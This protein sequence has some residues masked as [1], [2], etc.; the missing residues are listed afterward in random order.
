MKIA[1]IISQAVDGV[2]AFPDQDS[3]FDLAYRLHS[4]IW[5]FDI[6]NSRILMA[7]DAAC[8]VWQAPDEAT[9]AQRDLARDMSPTVAKRL[10]QYQTDFTES[11]ARFTELWTIYPSGE[12]KN[13]M[14]VY[15]GFRLKDGRMAMLC[16]AVGEALEQPEN[17]RSAEALLHTDVMITLF[18]RKGPALY[19]NPAARTLMPGSDARFEDLFVSRGDHQHL[20]QKVD[21]L[22]E[23]RMVSRL[24]T[25]A[26]QRWFD[27][28]VKRCSDAVTSDPAILVTAIDVSDLK[29]ARDTAK[30]LADRDQLTNLYNRAYLQSHLSWLEESGL[31]EGH[32]L[33]FFDVD[34]FK[35]VNDRFGHEAGDTVL[36]EI[37]QR[38]RATCRTEDLIVRFGGDEF[39]ILVADN[40]TR[41]GLEAQI[42]RLRTA[43]AQPIQHER[44]K[45]DL[46]VSVGVATYRADSKSFASVL[47]EADI[48]LYRA[49]AA[50]RN[51]VTFFNKTMGDA[52][53]ARETLEEELKEALTQGEFELH[54]QP[55]VDMASGR[56]VAVE[57]L[58]RWNHPHRGIVMPGEFIPVCEETGMIDELG[59]F[60]L[61]EGC[62]QAQMWQQ[63]GLDLVVSLNVS[64]RQ[65]DD[66]D[67]LSTLKRLAAAPDFPTNRIELEITENTLFGERTTIANKLREITA[68]GYR[69]AID[70]FGTGY[71]NLSYIS[72]FPL[73]SL[74]VDRSFIEQL[75]DSGPIVQLI[76]T[77][78]QQIGATVVSE[79][80]ETRNQYDWLARH[81]CCETQG[82]YISRAVPAKQVPE[83]VAD[84][85]AHAPVA[86][87]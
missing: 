56:V 19:L 18:S 28:S 45:L 24:K 9:L 3:S 53:R 43:M 61:E 5:A 77:L 47:R 83:F 39:I 12:P 1:P 8:S 13:L 58:A 22:G 63:S 27:L 4:P 60:V 49:K 52:V 48:A 86:S 66:R 87:S 55:R 14:V 82:F 70:D 42:A 67:F 85:D 64:P 25:A 73:T 35:Q 59:L 78:G 57:G 81:D 34:R 29:E 68:L 32:S 17:L 38:L 76:V 74:K 16:E 72:R 33:I 75:P 31:A 80:V 21:A 50:G 79:G 37:A 26:G 30:Y 46:T 54:Y 71:S 84:F 41:A 11:D 62:R 69:I 2:C 36:R 15:R 7:N 51:R 40:M 65:F 10:K 20:M 6:D 44:L 23:H